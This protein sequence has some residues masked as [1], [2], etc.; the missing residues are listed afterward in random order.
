MNVWILCM[1]LTFLLIYIYVSKKIISTHLFLGKRPFTAAILKI[2]VRQ[3]GVKKRQYL[4][5][6]W[7]FVR[8]VLYSWDR[9]GNL[10]FTD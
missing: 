3:K 4:Y 7:S 1:Q 5:L 2:I 6:C 10:T 8:L 9:D